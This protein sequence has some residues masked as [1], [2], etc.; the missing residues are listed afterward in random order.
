MESTDIHFLVTLL[1][2]KNNQTE[3]MHDMT[4]K[5]DMHLA[6]TIILFEQIWDTSK[7]TLNDTSQ[8]NRHFKACSVYRAIFEY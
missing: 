3:H 1:R 7:T 4:F 2:G 5:T 6:S 8:H